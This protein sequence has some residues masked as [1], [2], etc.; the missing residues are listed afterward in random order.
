MSTKDMGGHPL[1]IHRGTQDLP[2]HVAQ[3]D[4]DDLVQAGAAADRARDI[5][6]SLRLQIEQAG[7][8]LEAA[9]QALAVTRAKFCARYK[10]D[11]ATG[12]QVEP[13]TR[14]IVRGTPPGAPP[15]APPPPNRAARRAAAAARR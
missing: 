2:T 1:D 6:G 10:L 8:E 4:L 13:A 7:K 14:E 11:E 3:E 12:W 15:A 5:F 9:G